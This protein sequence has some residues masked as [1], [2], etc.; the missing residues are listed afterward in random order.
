MQPK[1]VVFDLQFCI[2]RRMNAPKR[3]D[4]KTAAQKL[5]VSYERLRN[6]EGRVIPAHYDDKGKVFFVIDEIQKFRRDPRLH[7]PSK[8]A[9]FR[10]L[11][12]G[13]TVLDL[14]VRYGIDVHRAK[15]YERQYAAAI[16]GIVIDG[17]AIQE[18]KERGFF[19]GVEVTSS[20]ILETLTKA[21]EVL[22]RCKKRSIV[23]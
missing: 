10:D 12:E 11:K 6:L 1:N 5:N 4:R 7:A 16:N 21:L 19:D 15:E 13:A 8:K 17:D 22:R 3:L 9:C 2:I 18:L 23:K 14:M 20:L